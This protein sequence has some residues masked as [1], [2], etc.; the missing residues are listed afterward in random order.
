MSG[1]TVELRKRGEVKVC[2]IAGV[3]SKVTFLMADLFMAVGTENEWAFHGKA[4]NPAV[5]T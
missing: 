4:P 1:V 5:H 2:A 3:Q